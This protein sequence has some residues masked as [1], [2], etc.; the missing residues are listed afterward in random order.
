MRPEQFQD[1]QFDAMVILG[2]AVWEGGRPSPSLL[3]RIN[4]AAELYYKGVAPLIIGSGGLGKHA[5]SEADVMARELITLGVPA[6]AILPENR[7][8]TTLENSVLSARIL[9]QQKAHKVL[10]VSD[11]YHLPRALLCFRSL[12]FA[13][14]G[15][16]PDK[17]NV[18][19]PRHKWLY[20]YLRE[21]A[22]YPW[23]VWK[24][25]FLRPRM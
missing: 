3:R 17:T 23:Y 9:R 18:K 21:F 15:S 16:G 20:S 11:R 22:A 6:S 13:A 7:S 8:H 5:P 25:R 2:A 1:G 19:T 14:I 12:G 24:L 4:H 10:V